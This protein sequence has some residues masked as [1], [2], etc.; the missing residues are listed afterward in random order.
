MESINFAPDFELK[1]I[2]ENEN[3]FVCTLGSLLK[4]GKILV[5]FIYPKDNTPGCTM[6]TC[7]FRDNMNRLKDK[8]IVI[9]LSSDSL[10]S[11]KKFQEKYGLPFPLL[12][13][14]EK[15]IIKQY[16]AFGKKTL[17]GKIVEGIIRSTFII[18]K[19]KRILKHWHKVSPK[20]HVEEILNFLK[21]LKKNTTD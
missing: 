8:T 9:G 15:K 20:G 14:P 1:G 18:D 17:Y 10:E 19:D 3:E 2:D 5:L 7:D 4:T 13:D 6:E 16:K 21:D 12:S 11:H